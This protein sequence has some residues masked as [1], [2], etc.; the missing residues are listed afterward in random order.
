MFCLTECA[1]SFQLKS[2]RVGHVVIPR[3]SLVA[4]TVK[5]C[6]QWGR[7]GFNPWIRKIPLEKGMATH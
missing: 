4:Q 3:A 7:Q 6:L 2:P 1:E 5:I